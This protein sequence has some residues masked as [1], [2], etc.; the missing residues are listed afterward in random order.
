MPPH[1]AVRWRGPNATVCQPGDN[2]PARL[3]RRAPSGTQ[4][5][6]RGGGFGRSAHGADR[7]GPRPPAAESDLVSSLSRFSTS[8]APSYRQGATVTGSPTAPAPP[9]IG[10]TWAR[11]TTPVPTIRRRRGRP[12]RP[13][14]A[15]RRRPTA[16]HTPLAA[17]DG[18]ACSIEASP[19]VR[20]LR[21]VSTA[22]LDAIRCRARRS[23]RMPKR[24]PKPPPLHIPYNNL[25]S[26]LRCTAIDP[27]EPT[28]REVKAVPAESAMVSG[29]E[30]VPG[31][32][33]GILASGLVTGLRNACLFMHG[34][35][36]P[37]INGVRF[38]VTN[39]KLTL[40]STNCHQLFFQELECIHEGDVGFTFFL[41]GDEVKSLTAAHKA[42][43]GILTLSATYGDVTVVGD[44][45]G[46]ASTVHPFYLVPDGVGLPDDW[47]TIVPVEESARP[48]DHISIDARLLARIARIKADGMTVIRFELA[49]E[50]KP[51]VVRVPNGPTVVTMPLRSY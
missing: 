41:S 1:C 4:P 15:G 47:R 23:V 40:V 32:T 31:R 21:A 6:E 35:S 45:A 37:D 7:S 39:G 36:R 11:S 22:R 8:S 17:P 27:V 51:A 25:R 46:D 26:A 42:G 12:G 28:Q 38:E 43:K 19:L 14:A 10:T 49:G 18:W 50:N 2:S 30:S 16:A 48:T 44:R 9:A 5:V 20:R 33:A 13:V 34:A 3:R 29:A 24:K